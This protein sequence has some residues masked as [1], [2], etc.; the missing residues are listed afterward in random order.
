M[1]WGWHML[2]A[3]LNDDSLRMVVEGTDGASGIVACMVREGS[4]VDKRR[5]SAADQK[6]SI[7]NVKKLLYCW[8]FAFLR[9]NGTVGFLRATD[10]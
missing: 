6:T 9:N 3:Q 7:G 1:I 4:F 5:C 10:S 2:V 8:E